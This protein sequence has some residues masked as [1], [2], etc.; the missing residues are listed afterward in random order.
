MHVSKPQ[1]VQRMKSY[2]HFPNI[3]PHNF[4]KF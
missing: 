1:R 2:L 3:F 4:N